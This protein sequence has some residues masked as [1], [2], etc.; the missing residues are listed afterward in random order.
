MVAL[1]L[2]IGPLAVWSVWHQVDGARRA[3]AVAATAPQPVRAGY[4][5]SDRCEACHPAQ[6]Q[7][8][9][10]GYHRT[11]TQYASPAAVRG[12]FADVTLSD[13]GDAIHL[14][15]RGDEFYAEMVD[16]L[17]QYQVDIGQRELE[18]GQP[19]PRVTRRISMVTG[20]H[21]MQA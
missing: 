9:H 18:P 7:S 16:P 6:Y 5:T 11:M 13:G 12:D 19:R 3:E 20:S 21:H 2:T 1:A 17:W 10:R 15:R 4:A 8:W 14:S